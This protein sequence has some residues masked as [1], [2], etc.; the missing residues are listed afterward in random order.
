MWDGRLE[1]IVKGISSIR[2]TGFGRTHIPDLA[3]AHMKYAKQESRSY[4]LQV[5][6][7]KPPQMPLGCEGGLQAGE[8][9]E[10]RSWDP[11]PGFPIKGSSGV[12]AWGLG[13]ETS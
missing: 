9:L 12:F 5:Q 13:K 6:E 3:I 2:R 8:E 4:A 10:P 1:I 7:T 11:S